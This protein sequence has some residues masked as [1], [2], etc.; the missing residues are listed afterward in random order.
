MFWMKHVSLAIVIL[1]IAGIVLYLQ[2]SRVSTVRPD[3]E[4]P[5]SIAENMSDFYSD[6]KLTSRDPLVEEL[7]DF[8]LPVT[9]PQEPLTNRL[10]KMERL[11]KPTSGRWVGE[12]KHRSFKSG[13][14]L[15]SAIT[16][17]AELEGMQ[18]IWELDQDFIIKHTFQLDDSILGS[19]RM[20]ATA[21]DANFDGEVKAYMCPKQRSLVITE[22]DT[23]YLRKYCALA[24]R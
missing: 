21:I 19:L 12:H 15:R 13:S 22:K 11:Q 16:D 2:N 3:G 17:Y 1:V 14:T 24:R 7:G 6:Y 8:V 18:V 23:D 5:K 10:R 20:I 4:G 9:T